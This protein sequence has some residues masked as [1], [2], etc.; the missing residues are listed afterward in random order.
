MSY[1]IIDSSLIEELQTFSRPA[2][3]AIDC[4]AN[5]INQ[6]FH[7]NQKVSWQYLIPCILKKSCTRGTHKVP[8]RIRDP[9]LHHKAAKFRSFQHIDLPFRQCHQAQ[10][11]LDVLDQAGYEKLVLTEEDVL[12]LMLILG[13]VSASKHSAWRL[14]LFAMLK[15]SQSN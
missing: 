8:S 9:E 1:R 15:S 5:A 14:Q 13:P 11:A 3:H 7:I 6:C 10:T 2:M 12:E 4:R